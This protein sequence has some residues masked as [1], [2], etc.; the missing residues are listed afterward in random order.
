[1]EDRRIRT[2]YSSLGNCQGWKQYFA[3]LWLYACW[4][5]TSSLYYVYANVHIFHQPGELQ[6]DPLSRTRAAKESWNIPGWPT[7]PQSM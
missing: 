1:M 2:G 3:K 6:N 7:T 5:S 4:V